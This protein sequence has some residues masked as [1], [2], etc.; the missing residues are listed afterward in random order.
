MEECL[1][2]WKNAMQNEE[3]HEQLKS[4]VAEELNN[5]IKEVT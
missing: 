2:E 3:R 5:G 1:A 4:W